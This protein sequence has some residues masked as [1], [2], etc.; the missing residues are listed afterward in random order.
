MKPE[1]DLDRIADVPDP[2]SSVGSWPLPPRRE[3]AVAPSPTRSRVTAARATALGLALLY[4][5]A[6]LAIMNKRGDLHTIPG[7][8]LL[9]EVAVPIV[10]AIVALAAVPSG[11]RS[12]GQPIGRMAGLLVLSPALFVAA[13]IL[14]SP[15]DVD[16]E[17][18]WLHGLRCFSGRPSTRPVPSPW[19]RGRSGGRSS[20]RRSGEARPSAWLA[21]RP[22]WRR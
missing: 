18:F 11:E 2:L 3:P 4:E 15:G 17:S 16:G 5:L 8:T 21:G 22:A 20:R 6:W 10:A 13:T 19:R 9:A 12:L 14:V 1:F 7:A